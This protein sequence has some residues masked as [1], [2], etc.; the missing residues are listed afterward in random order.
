[1]AYHNNP[2]HWRDSTTVTDSVIF[3]LQWWHL[4][5]CFCCI[6]ENIRFAYVVCL[7]QLRQSRCCC[8]SIHPIWLVRNISQF[9]TLPP[10]IEKF[11]QSAHKLC[12]VFF[13]GSFPTEIIRPLLHIVVEPSTPLPQLLSLLI[14]LVLVPEFVQLEPSKQMFLLLVPLFEQSE[15]FR[16]M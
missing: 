1:M 9:V 15:F 8:F 11:F 16:H 4:P 14:T 10:V 5:F 7:D 13:S 12:Y 2:F 3:L 6:T